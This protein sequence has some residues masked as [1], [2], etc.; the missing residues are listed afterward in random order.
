MTTLMETVMRKLFC[1]SLIA[2]ISVTP[3]LA[4]P[5][6]TFKADGTTYK[7]E[8]HRLRTDDVL[9]TGL[10]GD[11]GAPFRLTVHGTSVSGMVGREPVSFE[12]SH[13]TRDSL[14]AETAETTTIASK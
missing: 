12:I 5:V 8:A 6:H 10:I 7:Y 13:A 2:T 4:A 3:A 1:A 14:D 9:I 11:T